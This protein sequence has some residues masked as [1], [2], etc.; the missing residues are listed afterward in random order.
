MIQSDSSLIRPTV[1]L[2]LV[3]LIVK[4]QDWWQR[5][6]Q[7]RGLMVSTIAEQE[8]VNHS[9]VTRVL[10]LAFLSPQLVQAII[11]CRQPVWVDSGALCAPDAIAAD[12][13]QQKQR[14]LLGRAA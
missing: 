4:A 12:W 2:T 9:Y 6:Q 1:D 14:L 8:G 5:L 13:E 10:R 11:D 7:E 3:R